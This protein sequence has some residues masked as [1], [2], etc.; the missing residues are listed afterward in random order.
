MVVWKKYHSAH[1]HLHSCFESSASMAGHCYQAERLGVDVVWTTDHDSRICWREDDAFWADDFE[2]QD[3]SAPYWKGGHHGWQLSEPATGMQGGSSL[4]T[5]CSLSGKQSMRVWARSEKSREEWGQIRVDFSTSGKR[6]Q[7]SLIMGV[8]IG[9]ALRPA[10]GFGENGRLLLAMGLSQQPPEMDQAVMAY[11][12]GEPSTEGALSR[13]PLET[14]R[15]NLIR[16]DLTGDA[17]KSARGGADNVFG[18]LSLI[19]ESRRGQ[20]VE[21]FVDDFTLDQRLRCQ[22][23]YEQQ[24]QL[25]STYSQRYGIAVHV[26]NEGSASGRHTSVF[27]SWIPLFNRNQ[28]PE[29]YPPTE[30]FNS[31]QSQGG[32]VSINHPFARWKREDLTLRGK[33]MVVRDLVKSLSASHCHGANLIEVGFPE[34]RH[35]FSLEQYMDLWD[36]LSMAGVVVAAIGVS[37]AHNNVSGWASGNNFVN[38][39][40]SEVPAERDLIAGLLSGDVFMGDPTCFGGGLEFST[41]GGHR[42]GQIVCEADTMTA[43]I[44][45]GECGSGWQYRW[46]LNGSREEA[47]PITGPDFES[48]RELDPAGL[49]FARGEVY[50]REGRCILLTNPVYSAEKALPGFPE[51][52]IA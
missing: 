52:R 30:F 2:G 14:G 50:D 21:L 15:W 36:G 31:I 16:L 1:L 45:L 46:V 29:G 40:R 13:P 9:L 34:G 37:D 33:G 20:L 41:R 11:T 17:E 47:M 7:R 4:T 38:W 39:I 35:G 32:A 25:A 48:E 18:D 49:A 24:K 26:G 10:S 28:K 3:L 27:G 44:H 5:N 43:R 12:F 22:D 42:M 19:L 8:N 6:H 23:A 51:H